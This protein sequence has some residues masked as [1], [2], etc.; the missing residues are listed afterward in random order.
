MCALSRYGCTDG[1][2]FLNLIEI[3]IMNVKEIQKMVRDLGLKPGKLKKTE[4]VRLIQKEEK[5]D[6]CYATTAV[7][8]CRQED[9][10]WLADCLKAQ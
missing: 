4:L 1:W 9:C 3:D 5:N 7:T 2:V 8:S 10:L 6:E